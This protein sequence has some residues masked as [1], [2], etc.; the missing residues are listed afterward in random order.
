MTIPKFK[1]MY[2][3][4]LI[5]KT[6]SLNNKMKLS[7]NSQIMHSRMFGASARLKR[8]QTETE[9]EDKTQIHSLLFMAV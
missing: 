1:Y 5:F 8:K 6:F 4:P 3:K 2:C 7:H 9:N